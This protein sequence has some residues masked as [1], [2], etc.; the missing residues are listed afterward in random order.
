[1][2]PKIDTMT[3]KEY[4]LKFS[5]MG[6]NNWILQIEKDGL[7]KHEETIIRCADEFGRITV[8]KKASFLKSINL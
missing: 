5:P 1:M 8:N 2:D 7:K 4:V 6:I 3:I